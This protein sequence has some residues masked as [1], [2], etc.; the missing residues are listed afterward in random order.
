MSTTPGGTSAQ[1]ARSTGEGTMGTAPTQQ[2][3]SPR[4]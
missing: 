1:D 4:K 2:P 3:N